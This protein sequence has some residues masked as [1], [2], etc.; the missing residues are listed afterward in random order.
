DQYRREGGQNRAQKIFFA[1]LHAILTTALLVQ[2]PRQIEND[3]K[4]RELGR[5]DSHGAEADPA[6]RGVGAVQKECADQH[7]HNSAKHGINHRGLTQFVVVRAHQDE[8][9][10]E[11]D[12]K[13]GGLPHKENVRMA[14]QLLRGNGGDT[15]DNHLAK[16]AERA[17]LAEEPPVAV[18]SCRHVWFTALS[19]WCSRLGVRADAPAL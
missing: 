15:Q 8:H 9:P 18:W 1:K 14:V 5:L 10:Q 16:Q 7:E 19:K 4:F 3:G 13:P 12:K 11:A 17:R 2:K 6:M